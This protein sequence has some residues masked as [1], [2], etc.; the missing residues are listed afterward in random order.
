MGVHASCAGPADR[1]AS[2]RRRGG[3]LNRNHVKPMNK[4]NGVVVVRAKCRRTPCTLLAF[5]PSPICV[6]AQLSSRCPL[7]VIVSAGQRRQSL[8][9]VACGRWPRPGGAGRERQEA[10]GHTTKYTTVILY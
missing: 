2:Q 4:G 1:R 5:V 9:L 7:I 10:G 8:V 3:I 6:C